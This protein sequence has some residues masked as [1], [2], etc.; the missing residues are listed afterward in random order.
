MESQSHIIAL[1]ARID[2]QNRLVLT[3]QDGDRH[4]ALRATAGISDLLQR[5]PHL[6]S[7]TVEVSDFFQSGSIY[8]VYGAVLA[9]DG[10]TI[11]S[12][13]EP[14][15]RG[16]RHQ[17]AVVPESE[18]RNIQLV[19]G[20]TPRRPGAPAPVPFTSWATPGGSSPTDTGPVVGPAR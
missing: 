2:E 13:W 1:T 19:I 15:G 11:A 6:A 17:F 4:V 14:T 9:G 8:D 10:A 18:A 16:Q 7:V 3:F 12:H 5:A 20:A